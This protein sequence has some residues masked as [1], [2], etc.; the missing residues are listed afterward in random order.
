MA[1][2]WIFRRDVNIGDFN[3]PG[4]SGSS[5]LEKKLTMEQYVI[6]M[7]WLL[8]MIPSTVKNKNILN[9]EAI[10]KFHGRLFYYLGG[11]TFTKGIQV[12]GLKVSKSVS[13]FRLVSSFPRLVVF[14]ITIGMS[15]LTELTSNMSST[16]IMILFVL[17]SIAKASRYFS[18]INH[19][20]CHISCF[21]CLHVTSGYGSKRNNIWL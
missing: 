5:F 12:S 14:S 17:A 10:T 3:F 8:F 16:E 21:M 20:S 6:F 4:W 15:F 2:S 1:L 9:R 7:L 18:I 11:F 13:S 19:D